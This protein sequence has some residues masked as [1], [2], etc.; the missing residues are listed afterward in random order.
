MENKRITTSELDFDGIK[1]SLKNFLQGQDKFSDYNFEGSG[2]SVLLDVLAY[3]THYNALYTNLAVNESFLDSASKRNS[4]VSRAK[5]LGYTPRSYR[6]ATARI[7]LMI[8]SPF[9]GDRTYLDLPKYTAFSAKIGDKSYKF[10]TTDDHIAYK[11]NNQFVFLDIEV[12]QG[13]PLQYRYLVDTG[14]QFIIPNAKADLTTLEVRVQETSSSS[15]YEVF[16]PVSSLINLEA[17]S[18]VYFVK[19]IDG[20]LYEIEFGDNVIGKAV[21]PG[22][23]VILDYMICDGDEGNN[24]SSFSY[25]GPTFFSNQSQTIS[26]A[27]ASFGGSKY[28]DVESVRY[29]A[30]HYYTAQNR[31]VTVQDYKTI[32]SS[33]FPAK[34]INIWGG[35]QHIPKMYGNVYIAVIPD[36][37]TI[38][39]NDE[40]NYIL[41]DI[42]RPRNMMTVHPVFVDPVYIKLNLNVT[43]HYD[44]NKTQSKPN[45]IVQTIIQNLVNFNDKTLLRFNSVFRRSY[46]TALIDRSNEAIL[47]SSLSIKLV[48]ETRAF[49]NQLTR[50]EIYL[51][52]P[53]LNCGT[54]VEHIKSDTIYTAGFPTTL[55][56]IDDQPLTETSGNLRLVHIQNSQKIVLKTIGKVDYTTGY[57]VIYDLNVIQ[58]ANG[59]L[60]FYIS[61]ASTDVVSA[62]NQVITIDTSNLVVVPVNVR[63]S[64]TYKFSSIM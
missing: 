58:S 30:P 37:G 3:N 8:T 19:E 55:C 26:P 21:N 47:N 32:I 35:E 31:L 14:T 28:E 23:V 60:K 33:S 13:T 17:T 9:T 51:D 54:P 39:T 16:Q 20:G 6:A 29:T 64:S 52:N 1:Q 36:D 15:T 11:N 12:K 40:K 5:A 43:F 56:Y 45:D 7:N 63:D 44:S 38:L 22:N 57:L 53:I 59:N 41:N 27:T 2:L 10:Y 49:I 18:L 62:R 50:Y 24:A 25:N 34:S 4:V 42:I 46:V 48:Y 61:P